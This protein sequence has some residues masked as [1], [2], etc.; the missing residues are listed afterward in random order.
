M[1]IKFDNYRVVNYI[2]N[3][4]TGFSASIY[5]GTKK[6]GTAERL[7]G[8][9]EIEDIQIK[10]TKESK[11]DILEL[12]KGRRRLMIDDIRV[13]WSIQLMVLCLIENLTIYELVK[14]DISKGNIIIKLL[15]ED[16]FQVLNIPNNPQNLAMV[17]KNHDNIEMLGSDFITEYESKYKILIE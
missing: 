8:Y 7:D 12:L 11:F 3:G 10:L 14:K 17:K 9:S 13:N 15:D 6:V 5:N 4:V 16:F 1:Y 2:K